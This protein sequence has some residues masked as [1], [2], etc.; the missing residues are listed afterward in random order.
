MR[1]MKEW[2]LLSRGSN[3]RALQ[4]RELL[5][6]RLI[7][8]YFHT[9]RISFLV[10][11]NVSVGF[12][13]TKERSPFPLDTIMALAATDPHLSICHKTNP[14]LDS[15]TDI[16]IGIG[17]IKQN[18]QTNKQKEKKKKDDPSRKSDTGYKQITR[19]IQVSKLDFLG[20]SHWLDPLPPSD[21][22]GACNISAT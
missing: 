14:F 15:A 4:P 17:S 19:W 21:D 6:W 20:C 10:L 7:N 13:L 1:R 12:S 11:I 5:P 8:G 2:S 22:G 9:W 18:K 3:K 16:G